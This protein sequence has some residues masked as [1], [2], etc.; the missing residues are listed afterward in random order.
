MKK[1]GKSVVFCIVL[2]I[3][4]NQLYSVFSWKDTAGGYTS[5]VNA[6][7]EFKEDL[8]DVLFLGSSHCYCSINNSV[9]WQEQGIASFSLAISGQDLV[10][11][12]HCLKEALKTQTP[13]VVCLE[14]YGAT[15]HGYGVESNMYRNTLSLRLSG[16]AI[17]NIRNIAPDR[18]RELTL[19]WPIIH[20]RYS[21][22]TE[23]DFVDKSYPYLGY[24]AEFH[25]H[26]VGG[27]CSYYGEEIKPINEEEEKWLR[28]IIELAKEENIDV[29]LFMAPVVSSQ[30]EQM[31]LNYV[32]TIADEYGIHMINMPKMQGELDINPA[33][34]FIDA[35]H[36]NYYGSQKVSSYM[37]NFLKEHYD[38]KDRRGDESYNIWVEDAKA[39]KHEWQNYVLLQ[40]Y[41]LAPYVEQLAEYEDYTVIMATNG[42][43]GADTGMAEGILLSMGILSPAT[44]GGIW[45]IDN[46]ELIVE[47]GGGNFFAYME[48]GKSDLAVSSQ[49]GTNDVI[50]DQISHIKVGNGINIVVYDKLMDKVIDVVGFDAANAYSLVR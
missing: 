15:F 33:T 21:E 3:F 5:S 2:A 29:C 30:E 47:S 46:G 6:L 12:Y 32:Q 42:N 13:E 45:V 43:Y 1:I 35:T 4:L 24:L 34:D 49:Q 18:E 38:L 23:E 16:D 11:S 44:N 7:Y 41:D 22:L 40:T 27:L 31:A 48:I 28:K 14:L 25:C 36:T 9:L 17:S 50:I 37:G 20:T 26:P 10:S 8:V 19:R 39:R